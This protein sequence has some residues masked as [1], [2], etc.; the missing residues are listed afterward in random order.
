LTEWADPKIMTAARDSVKRAV[1]D[2]GIEN[3]DLQSMNYV[4]ALTVWADGDQL[5]KMR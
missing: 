5:G 4:D 1:D 3:E 2:L